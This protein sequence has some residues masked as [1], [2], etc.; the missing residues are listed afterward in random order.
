MILPALATLPTPPERSIPAPADAADAG[1]AVIVAKTVVR[2]NAE[3]A[4]NARE[5]ADVGRRAAG[6][7][8]GDRA[9]GPQRDAAGHRALAGHR[10][11]ETGDRV[12]VSRPA[13]QR[14]VD[15]GRGT[16]RDRGEGAGQG[17]AGHIGC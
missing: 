12:G 14:A 1:T 16:E 17:V 5:P 4:V 9:A 2:F 15:K 7:A 10:A 3:R 6:G 11:P 8:V 13:N